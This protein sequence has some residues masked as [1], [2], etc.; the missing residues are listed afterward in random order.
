VDRDQ[1]EDVITGWASLRS[2]EYEVRFDYSRFSEAGFAQV[3]LAMATGLDAQTKD[4]DN[5]I[6]LLQHLYRQGRLASGGLDEAPVA[7]VPDFVAAHYAITGRNIEIV[8]P[9]EGTLSFACGIMGTRSNELPPVDATTLMA[10]GF[11]LPDGRAARSLYPEGEAY[12]AATAAV[13]DHR[14][15]M[16]VVDS[17]A[18]F[19]RQVLGRRLY[20]P[21]N[22]AENTVTYL[23]FILLFSLW[24][25]ALYVRISDKLLR[26]RLF[27]ISGLLLLWMLVRV[28]RLFMLDGSIDRFL[29]YLYYV[30]LAFVPLVLFSIGQFL[31]GNESRPAR[32]IRRIGYQVSLILVLLVLSND[33]HQMAFHFYRGLEGNNYDRYYSHGWVYYAVFAWSTLLLI[34]F[35]VMMLQ[36]KRESATGR[37]GPL[38]LIH[39]LGTIYFAGYAAGV[40]IMRETEFSVVYGILSL[41]YL[42]VCF[43]NRLIPNNTSLGALLRNAQVDLRILSETL[44]V[45]YSSNQSGE[46]PHEAIKTIGELDPDAVFPVGF[47][48]PGDETMLYS[49]HGI[50]G[51]YAVFAHHLDEVLRLRE[52]L[53]EQNEKISMQ[54]RILVRTHTA[55]SEIAGLKAYQDLYSR[56]SR[57]LEERIVRLETVVTSLSLE[58]SA[59][60]QA[61]LYSQLAKIKVLVN[62]CK[63]RGNIVLLEAADENCHTESLALWLQ[64][65]LWEAGKAGVAGLVSENDGGDM[66]ASVAALLYDVFEDILEYLLRFESSVAM[67]NLSAN[68]GNIRLRMAIEEDTQAVQSYRELLQ[69]RS[70]ALSQKGGRC[71]ISLQDDVILI[72]IELPSGGNSHG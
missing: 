70:L 34:A 30:P 5:T 45:E 39:G 20:S 18:L 63:R 56:V 46:L 33:L 48:T 11:R 65:A 64:E 42:E 59:V 23:A 16:M 22:G 27:I 26:K 25:G 61:A 29:W 36:Q 72:I 51:G 53:A 28:L 47:Y 17:I 49:V 50:S 60:D 2:G 69:T 10:A 44:Q 62:Y 55:E 14:S 21:A 54:N 68:G 7:I 4:C 37:G 13:V 3:I 52:H 40:P 24:S 66:P 67:A 58:E 12:S 41:L 57:V 71:E 31:T 8:V 9:T 32:L 6:R 35:L 19:R 1:I 15:A 43:R 38:I